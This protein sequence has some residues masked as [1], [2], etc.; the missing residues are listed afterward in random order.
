ML[1]RNIFALLFLSSSIAQATDVVIT[2]GQLKGTGLLHGPT[3]DEKLGMQF[4]TLTECTNLPEEFD[5]RDLN[6][7]PPV[8]D[9]GGCGSCW[10]FSLTASLESAKATGNGEVLNL[11]EQQI[12]SC[13][14]NNY[15]CGGG[16]LNGFSYQIS[17]GQALESDFPYTARN[18]ACKSGLVAAAKGSSFAYAGASNRLATEQEVKCALFK[19]HTI[20]WITV[21][22]GGSEWSVPP[23]SD[24]GVFSR[25]SHGGTNHAV[26]LVGWKTINGK[27]YFKMRNSWG[28]NWGSTAGKPGAERGYAL[29][30][31][32]CDS[33]GEEVAYII[34]AAMTCQPPE[35][36]LPAELESHSG[37]LL[38]LGIERQEGVQYEWFVNDVRVAQGPSAIFHPLQTT[39]YKLVGKNSCGQSEI[40]SKIVIS[41]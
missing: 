34:P 15:G 33:L 18:S 5:L 36:K 19:S 8:K 13:D 4:S 12:V 37:Q 31:L 3:Q 14:R 35:V 17:K 28:K 6:V 25:C 40:S 20:P 23:T 27:A 7:V 1:L 30:P 11:S 16:Y 29:M 24:N 21:S 26:G 2:G 22:A 10:A 41:P 9:Q 32:G 38:R 39:V